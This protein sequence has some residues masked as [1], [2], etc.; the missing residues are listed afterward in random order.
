MGCGTGLEFEE[1]FNVNT[2]NA[3]YFDIYLG[4]SQFDTVVSVESLHHFTHQMKLGLYKKIY[5]SLKSGGIYI[6][7]NYMVE[8]QLEED[9]Y[10]SEIARIRKEQN[11][12]ESKF[13]HYNTPCTP[14]NQIK[15]LRAIGFYDVKKV[16]KFKNTVI[17]IS[18]KQ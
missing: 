11:I 15:L 6:E 16:W 4:R 13:I 5:E 3:N 10:F 17:I 14:E 2:N 9:F 12:P 7:A 1:I 18:K 8:S